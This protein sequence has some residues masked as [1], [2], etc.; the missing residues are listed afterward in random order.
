[1]FTTHNVL[2]PIFWKK[3]YTFSCKA[4]S[5]WAKNL[6]QQSK[7][8]K[9]IIKEAW[10]L[11]CNLKFGPLYFFYQ[12]FLFWKV[13]LI[14]IAN[15]AV[16][17]M[18]GFNLAESEPLPTPPK[19]KPTAEYYWVKMCESLKCNLKQ[20]PPG[21]EGMGRL[22]LMWLLI[23]GFNKSYVVLN[24]LSRFVAIGYSCKSLLTPLRFSGKDYPIK[25]LSFIGYLSI[26]FVLSLQTQ[27]HLSLD[28]LF[29][30]FKNDIT[31]GN[32][33]VLS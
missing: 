17:E 32:C 28:K 30:L 1:M 10:F 20:F 18:R 23:D 9:F 5:Y 29:E 6:I 24:S 2:W 8:V 19:K 11:W 14:F 33:L 13:N 26:S 7:C 21:Y 3:R 27:P 22:Y 12:F 25:I 16:L 15:Y 31:A 4:I